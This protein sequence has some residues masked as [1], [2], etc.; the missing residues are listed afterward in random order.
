MFFEVVIATPLSFPPSCKIMLILC[1]LE[2]NTIK[3]ISPQTKAASMLNFRVETL[4]Q[5]FNI[6]FDLLYDYDLN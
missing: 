3:Q 1:L 6:N 5:Y 2:V 4:R